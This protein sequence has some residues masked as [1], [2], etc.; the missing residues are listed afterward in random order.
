MTASITRRPRPLRS[1]LAA[2]GAIT[3]VGALLL[4]GCGDQTA[5]AEDSGEKKETAAP[6]AGKLPKKYQ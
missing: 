4:T 5:G 3:A 1:R 6:L 2:A